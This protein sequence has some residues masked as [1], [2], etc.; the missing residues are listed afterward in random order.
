MVSANSAT[1]RCDS[2]RCDTPLSS[3]TVMAAARARSLARRAE[4]AA[5]TLGACHQHRAC[6]SISNSAASRNGSSWSLPA[7]SPPTFSCFFFFFVFGLSFWCTLTAPCC[8]SFA[9]RSSATCLRRAAPFARLVCTLC[10]R[11]GAV[12]SEGGQFGAIGSHATRRHGH[13]TKGYSKAQLA[14]N[15]RFV[16]RACASRASR[17]MTHGPRAAGAGRLARGGWCW[18]LTNRQ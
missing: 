6:C 8:C 1:V 13:A 10:E 3:P 18:S 9:A 11:I 15:R 4:S 5:A 7:P 14:A 12:I 16:R 2:G 17:L